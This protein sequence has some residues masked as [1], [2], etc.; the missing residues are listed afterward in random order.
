MYLN[1]E[2]Y[3]GFGG[4]IG[5]TEYSFYELKARKKLD[6]WTNNRIPKSLDEYKEDIE[7]CMFLIIEQI[8]ENE[9]GEADVSSVS[10]D[11]IS[12]TFVGAKTSEQKLQDIYQKVIEIL[13][14]CLVSLGVNNEN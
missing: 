4:K 3:I 1:F 13:P 9:T 14:Q 5:L 8:Y 12:M 10:N 11:G 7:L 2:K 6:Y